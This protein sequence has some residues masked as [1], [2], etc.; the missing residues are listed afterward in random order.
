MIK[1]RL[2][3]DI[4]ILAMQREFA[5]DNGKFITAK[6]RQMVIY[7]FQK[8]GKPGSY[9]TNSKHVKR[10]NFPVTFSERRHRRH[11]TLFFD[12]IHFLYILISHL[13]FLNSQISCTPDYNKVHFVI[14]TFTLCC[15][16]A[17]HAPTNEKHLFSSSSSFLGGVSTKMVK[18]FHNFLLNRISFTFLFAERGNQ[19]TEDDIDLS[20][21]TDFLRDVN[22]NIQDQDLKHNPLRLYENMRLV[23]RLGDRKKDGE[24][25]KRFVPRNVTML[26]FNCSPDKYF[27][28]AKTDIAIY[29][30]NKDYRYNVIKTGPIDQQIK[31]IL[32]YILSETKDSE[33]ESIAFVQYPRKALERRLLM[34]FITGAMKR[35]IPTQ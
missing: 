24:L 35:N 8:A 3:F 31:D 6:A 28:G 21:V 11:A 16:L 17:A 34:R 12:L 27:P 29:D 33:E 32:E 23:R 19:L 20:L 25:V 30:Q 2:R 1:S 26:F 10:V 22:S 7:S 15:S 13:L 14:I 5:C 4:G 9:P 18:T